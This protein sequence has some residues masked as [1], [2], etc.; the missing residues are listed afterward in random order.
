MRKP[1]K[2]QSRL[3]RGPART[4]VRKHTEYTRSNRFGGERLIEAAIVRNSHCHAGFRS[5]AEIRKAL[6][7]EDPYTSKSTD[8]EGFM[9]SKARF[10]RRVEAK[11]IGIAAGQVRPMDR[12]L[13]SSDINW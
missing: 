11:D 1:L 8:I 4:L 3:N 13:L 9:T 7:D 12:E 2:I 5:H 10:V 6:G